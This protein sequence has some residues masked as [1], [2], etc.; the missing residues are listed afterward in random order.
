ME[1]ID[2]AGLKIDPITKSDLLNRILVRAKNGQKTFITTPYSEF[3]YHCLL[4]PK[5]EAMLN[6]SDFAVADGIGILWAAKFLSIPITAKNYL[7]KIIQSFWQAFWTLSLIIAKPS[8]LKI[9]IPEKIVGADLIWDLAKLAEKNNFSIYLLGGFN[10]TPKL[11]AQ[12]LISQFPNIIISGHSNKNPNNPTI[13]DDLN[14]ARPDLLFVAFGPIKQERW[15]AHALPNL[16]CKL[17]IGVGGTF[18]YLAGIK[19]MP[20]KFMRFRGLEWLW[21]LFTQPK[22]FRRIINATFGL[23]YILIKFKIFE[24]LPFRKNAVSVVINQ[25][26]E[27]FIA[28]F[29][30]EKGAVKALGR[31]PDAFQNYWQLPQGGINHGENVIDGAKR[32]LWEETNIKHVELIKISE[33]LNSYKWKTDARPIFIN[34]RYHY[35]GQQQHIVY[36]KFLGHNNEVKLDLDELLEW[37]WV[38]PEN[39]ENTLHKDKLSLVK[40]VIEDLKEMREKGILN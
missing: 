12:K 7:L 5:D 18:D 38:L 31:H 17:A 37:Q 13:Y 36:F 6:S 19:P 11:A 33:K 10:D 32:E 3:L 21:R 1:K 29:N 16:P 40:I 22:R 28:R 2:I 24:S 34:K 8:S 14:K 4:H 27:I 15:I 23:I 9:I 39:L 30:P 25:K 26:G 20:P 35:K